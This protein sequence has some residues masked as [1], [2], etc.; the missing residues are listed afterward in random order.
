M[1]Y[2]SPRL[3][4]KTAELVAAKQRALANACPSSIS[5]LT[6]ISGLTPEQEGP[7]AIKFLTNQKLPPA[8]LYAMVDWHL[9]RRMML[10]DG[11][12]YRPWYLH[13]DGRGKFYIHAKGARHGELIPVGRY[14]LEL[15]YRPLRSTERVFAI[16]GNTADLRLA[17]LTTDRA[18]YLAKHS[19]LKLAQRASFED[20]PGPLL[21]AIHPDFSKATSFRP[22]H[23]D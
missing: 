4:H 2:N 1:N 16:N 19:A 15:Q 8:S 11:L 7:I 22:E 20:P 13:G 18:E 9:A 17:N 21:Q 23:L 10:E 12:I 3:S 6:P 14:L 5:A